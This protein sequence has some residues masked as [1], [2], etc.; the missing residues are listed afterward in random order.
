MDFILLDF[1]L[2]KFISRKKP[3]KIINTIMS[4]WVWQVWHHGCDIHFKSLFNACMSWMVSF[5]RLPKSSIFPRCWFSFLSDHFWFSSVH[6]FLGHHLGKLQLNLKALHLL[7]QGCS[8]ML[9]RWPNHNSVLSCK[10]SPMFFSFSLVLRWRNSNRLEVG[11]PSN[12]SCIIP[13]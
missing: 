8:S 2:A 13:L 11:H 3:Q 7:D 4:N 1:T 12:Y 5:E 10:Y 6:V 9:S